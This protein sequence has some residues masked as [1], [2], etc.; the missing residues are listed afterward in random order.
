F[1]GRIPSALRKDDQRISRTECIAHWLH[2]IIRASDVL[3]PDQDAAKNLPREPRPHGPFCPVI[4]R[5]HWPR[6]AAED[7]WKRSPEQHEV[8]IAR[9]VRE[10]DAQS[11]F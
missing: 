3:P 9:M 7:L 11:R 4:V 10:V 8:E 1:S 5:C 6:P 2:R